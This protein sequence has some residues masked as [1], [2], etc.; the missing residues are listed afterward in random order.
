MDI[1]KVEMGNKGADQTLILLPEPEPLLHQ[2]GEPFRRSRRVDGSGS[3]ADF[4]HSGPVGLSVEM[5]V[6][7]DTLRDFFPEGTQIL[8]G[9]GAAVGIIAS[10]DGIDDHVL[11]SGLGI[12]E[13]CFD[14]R[15]GDSGSLYGCRSPGIQKD[16]VTGIS[17]GGELSIQ[18]L[19]LS[20]PL[21]QLGHTGQEQSFTVYASQR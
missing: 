2:I 15:Q 21:L 10:P 7:T 17:A 20:S 19:K 12:A 16:I 13:V 5:G 11:V 6:L 14:L 4:N 9:D 18:N 1:D 8:L 3:T